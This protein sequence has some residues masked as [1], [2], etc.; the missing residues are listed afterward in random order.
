[1]QRYLDQEEIYKLETTSLGPLEW[2]GLWRWLD[3][4]V[5]KA[6]TGRPFHVEWLEGLDPERTP[7]DVLALLRAITDELDATN[8]V[9]GPL[10]EALQVARPARGAPVRIGRDACPVRSKPYERMGFLL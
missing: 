6:Q 1:M 2:E 9:T 3:R 8:V 4:V 7:P 5:I 10:R